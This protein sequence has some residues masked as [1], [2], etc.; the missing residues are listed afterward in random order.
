MPVVAAVQG[1]FQEVKRPEE[2]EAA[3]QGITAQQTVPQGL[4]TQ[5]A[6]AVAAALLRPL[7]RAK[8]AV[9]AS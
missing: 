9:P 1:M 8:Q 7:I 2:P 5:A 4:L 3:V 6:V